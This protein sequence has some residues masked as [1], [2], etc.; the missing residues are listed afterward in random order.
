MLIIPGG[1][2]EHAFMKFKTFVAFVVNSFL[3]PATTLLEPTEAHREYFIWFIF[4]K[5]TLGLGVQQIILINFACST[6]RV[7]LLSGKKSL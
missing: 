7:G 5:A 2:I 6:E 3:P 4:Y 1:N